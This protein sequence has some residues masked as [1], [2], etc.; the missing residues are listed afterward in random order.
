[1]ITDAALAVPDYAAMLRLDGQTAIVL[2]AGQGIGRQTAHALSQ[3]GARVGC[4]GRNPTRTLAVATETGGF[5]LIGDITQRADMERMFDEAK[6]TSGPIH[7]V[8]DIV[9]VARMKP[10]LDV[11]DDDWAAQYDVALR[12][13]FLAVQVGGAAAAESATPSTAF[14][15]AGGTWG[16]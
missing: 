13:V 11:T 8:V 1:M 15:H 16:N 6:R 12:H 14:T 9:G 10:L 4:V 7:H 3:V 5:P 2:G